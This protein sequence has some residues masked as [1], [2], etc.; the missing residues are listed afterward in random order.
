MNLADYLSELLGQHDEVSMPGLGY[1]VRERVNGYYSDTET[2]FHPPYNRIKYIPQLQN[3]DTLAQYVADKKNISLATSKYFAEKFVGNLKEQAATAVVSFADLGSFQTEGDQ[4]IFSPSYKL[5]ND[6]SFY[7]LEPLNLR[8][9]TRSVPLTYPEVIEPEEI[10][11]AEPSAQPVET[12]HEVMVGEVATVPKKNWLT[13][14][15]FI[16]AIAIV[17]LALAVWQVFI[18]YPSAFDKFTGKAA[19]VTT[20]PPVVKND[21]VTKPANTDTA[22]KAAAPAPAA[23]TPVVDT[24]KL[25]HVEIIVGSFKTPEKANEEIAN[26]KA[27]GVSAKIAA[28]VPGPRIKLSAGTYFTRHEAE[29]AMHILMNAGKISKNSYSQKIYPQK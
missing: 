21:T 8:K 15:W 4:L 16:A 10:I 9:F 6:F 22:A 28:D 2:I 19:A 14:P 23:T 18:F 11:T 12:I 17:I 29:A 25:A 13:S 24:A 3:D 7:G 26:L 27:K 20:A 1:F 5:D